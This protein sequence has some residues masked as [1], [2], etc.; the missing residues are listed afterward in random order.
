MTADRRLWRRVLAVDLGLF[1]V[2]L[3]F[4]ALPLITPYWRRLR[5]RPVAQPAGTGRS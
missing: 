1:N 3:F 2:A 5:G 4:F